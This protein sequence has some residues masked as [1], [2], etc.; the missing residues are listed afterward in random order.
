MIFLVYFE[1]F[2]AIP[3]L[4]KRINEYGFGAEIWATAVGIVS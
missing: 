3:F 2:A 4:C 1:H